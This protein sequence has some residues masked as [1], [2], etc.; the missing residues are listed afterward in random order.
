MVALTFTMPSSPPK[1]GSSEVMWNFMLDPLDGR[2][3]DTI[4]THAI[5]L[6]KAGG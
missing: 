4:E 5:L 6:D 2:P 3:M 1:M